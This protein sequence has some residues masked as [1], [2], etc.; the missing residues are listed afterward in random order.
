MRKILI[1]S[2]LLVFVFAGSSFGAPIT[3]TNVVTFNSAG[4]TNSGDGTGSLA[5][6]GRG[7]VNLLNGSG[8]YVKWTQA[9]TF[10]PSPD[11]KTVQGKLSIRLRDDS[12]N[13][14]DG[15]EFA[16]GW[17]NNGSWA[18]GEVDTG[19]Y[20]YNVSL[21]NGALTV[22]LASLGG[23]FYIDSST[24]TVNYSA[25]TPVPEP[26][27]LVLVGLGMLSAGFFARKRYKS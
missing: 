2:V 15:P 5:G 22:T 26:A 18:I 11:T 21:Q 16:L 1:V 7:S 19:T 23:D 13:W 27:S 4:A 9:F 8:D 25:A 6:Y 20:N 14:L 17:T 10:N 24:L 3:L 12:N